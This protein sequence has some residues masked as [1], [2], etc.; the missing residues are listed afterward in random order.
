MPHYL[1]Q[2]PIWCSLNLLKAQLNLEDRY[3]HA[4]FLLS[5]ALSTHLLIAVARFAAYQTRH[6][7]GLDYSVPYLVFP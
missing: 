4:L 7:T 5:L 3:A 2:Y 1:A 6:A